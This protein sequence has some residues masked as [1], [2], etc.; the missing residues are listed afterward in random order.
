MQGLCSLA[1][2]LQ[3][4]QHLPTKLKAPPG[5]QRLLDVQ[6]D[7][8]P[9]LTSISWRSFSQA[10]P[11]LRGCS[12]GRQELPVFSGRWLLGLSSFDG[13]SRG[14]EVSKPRNPSQHQWY[15]QC[16]SPSAL[17]SQLPPHQ[18]CPCWAIA[19]CQHSPALSC[20]PLSEYMENMGSH[21]KKTLSAARLLI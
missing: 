12:E 10:Q 1:L 7:A 18:K 16:L 4:S 9:E 21:K 15:L 11:Q 2:I 19:V 8:H 6:K 14:H 17:K 5:S 20:L 13:V 3:E